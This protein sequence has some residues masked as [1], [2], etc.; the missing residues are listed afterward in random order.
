[1]LECQVGG[2]VQTE[3]LSVLEPCQENK[4]KIKD[5]QSY[6]KIETLE[7]GGVDLGIEGKLCT[8][9]PVQMDWQVCGEL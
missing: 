5:D 9:H 6:G 7:E 2:K 4:D 1:M 8:S 3:P